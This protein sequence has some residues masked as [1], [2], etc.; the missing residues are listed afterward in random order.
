MVL[1]H[2]LLRLIVFALPTALADVIA[3]IPDAAP[4][5]FEQWV[6]PIVSALARVCCV[7]LNSRS[8]QV[9]P[10]KNVSGDAD[11]ASAVAKARAFVSKLTLQEK[12]NITTGVGTNGRCV[13]NTGVRR[14]HLIICFAH[15]ARPGR[16]QARLQ[17]SLSR[18]LAPGC[19]SHRLCI[20]IVRKCVVGASTLHSPHVS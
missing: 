19:P 4:S 9:V 10:A 6:S 1:L 18:G 5:G 13:G 12:I 17:W 15:P 16:P 8:V 2:L 11:W 7:S 14:P 3:R 20:R